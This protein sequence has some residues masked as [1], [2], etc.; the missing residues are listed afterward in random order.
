MGSGG[1]NQQHLSEDAKWA[2]VFLYAAIG[3]LVEIVPIL[4]L[5]LQPSRREHRLSEWNS[6]LDAH[7]QEVIAGLFGAISIFLVFKGGFA[8]VK[9]V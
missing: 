4:W 6:W 8:I 1:V 9:S 5:T 7:W 3:T 2:A